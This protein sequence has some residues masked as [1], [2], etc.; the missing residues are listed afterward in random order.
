MAAQKRHCT[1]YVKCE[2]ARAR[3]AGNIL[4]RK[5]RKIKHNAYYQCF[6]RKLLWGKVGLIIAIIIPTTI[7]DKGAMGLPPEY[8]CYNDNDDYDN[9]YYN[10]YS[11]VNTGTKNIPYQFTTCEGEKEKNKAKNCF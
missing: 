5:V 2:L 7:H 8:F 11:S 1:L 10:E 9:E 3:S 6:A 4:V